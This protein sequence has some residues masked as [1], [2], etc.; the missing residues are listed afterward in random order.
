MKR[1]CL[2][3]FLAGLLASAPPPGHAQTVSG[4][5][6]LGAN[7]ATLRGDG[8]GNLGYRTAASGGLFVE[9]RVAD[10]LALRSELLFSQKGARFDTENGELTL[11]A[12]YLE[13]PV[14]VVGQLP[15]FRAYAPHLVAGPALSLKLF[16]RQGAPGFSVDTE[17]TVFERT[18]VG[19]MVGAGASLG[20]P[21]A[22]QLEVRYTLGLRDVTRPVTT[23]PLTGTIPDDGVNGV[24][25]IMARLG[26]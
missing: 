6:L 22:L 10:P 23:D 11:K 13:A 7:V 18:D 21:G 8:G 26:I 16:E 1:L 15:F 14:L 20:G 24:V 12:N 4:G 3:L 17:E 2:C 5:L 9:L 25:S 19:V